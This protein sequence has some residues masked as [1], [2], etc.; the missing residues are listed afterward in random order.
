MSETLF[1]NPNTTIA[2]DTIATGNI[3]VNLD[4]LDQWL[5]LRP[6]VSNAATI[7]AGMSRF[8]NTYGL[9]S[10]GTNVFSTQAISNGSIFGSTTTTA[11]YGTV[12]MPG[13]YVF[14]VDG[15]GPSS[16]ILFSSKENTVTNYSVT[17][18]GSN[19]T[20]GGCLIP[21]GRFVI[22]PNGAGVNWIVWNNITRTSSNPISLAS[23]QLTPTSGCCL[24]ADGNMVV[25]STQTNVFLLNTT[26]FAVS[27]ALSYTGTN[28]GTG[29]CLDPTGNVVFPP[30]STSGVGVWNPTTGVLTR[31]IPATNPSGPCWGTALTGDGRVVFGTFIENNNIWVYNPFTLTCTTYSIAWAGSGI[32]FGSVRAM[33]DGRVLLVPW[34]G[35]GQYFGIFNHITNTVT[36]FAPGNGVPIDYLGSSFVPD[37]RLILANTTG[38]SNVVAMTGFSRGVPEAW[39]LHPFFN[40]SPF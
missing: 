24:N 39:C 32:R 28:F 18:T 5:Y 25:R 26:T 12:Y 11:V 14:Q 29:A 17:N 40:K 4:L 30:N 8:A 31:V 21:D 10:F 36:T 33:P 35:G 20:I 22:I 9:R 7:V 1:Y 15:N 3:S 6:S 2:T 23:G 16:C 37:G 19:R 27:N 13:G 34:G 38:R